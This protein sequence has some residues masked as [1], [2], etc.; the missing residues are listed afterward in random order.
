MSETSPIRR[1]FADI[2]SGQIHY[3]TAGPVTG[4][5]NGTPLVAIHQSPGS[6]KQ[7][8]ALLGELGALGR[9]VI[10]P[11]TPGNGDSPALPMEQP[12][13]PDLARAAFAAVDSLTTGPFDLYDSHTGAAIA[14]EIAI[15]HPTR[16]R[17]IVIDGMGLYSGGLQSEVLDRYA[18]EISP[19]AEAT[20]LM[21]VWH[22]CRDQHLF[23]PY[24]NRTAQ[25]R[26]PDGLPDD[27]YMHDFSVEVL[28]ALRT[29]HLSYRAAFRHPKRDR[30]PLITQPAMVVCST[31]DM[32]FEYFDDV[33]R[34]IPGAVKAELRA[35]S[36]PDHHSHMARTLHDFLEHA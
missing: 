24:Y 22:F 20:H 6:S 34:L 30:L 4:N 3:R 23:W 18:R 25:G 16:V 12:E 33:A 2:D 26:L 14:M 5:P 35:W 11:D 9:H 31:S 13:I 8:E 17:K 32:L 15:A 7:L 19:D 36:A 29:Y 21:K 27:D 10:A 1:G 28:K